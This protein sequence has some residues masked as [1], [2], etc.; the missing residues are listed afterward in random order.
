M[1]VPLYLGKTNIN[2]P[3]IR[4]CD[5]EITRGRRLALALLVKSEH[6]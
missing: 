6:S 1:L 3:R 5:K 2:T 4:L